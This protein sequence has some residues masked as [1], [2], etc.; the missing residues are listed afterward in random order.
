MPN[1][2]YCRKEAE[3][4]RKLAH[5]AKDSEAAIR[6]LAL[7]RDYE[8]HADE[9][10]ERSRSVLSVSHGPLQQQEIQQ[11]PKKAEDGK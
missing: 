8:A 11:Q 6:W 10:D 3:R 4:C 1:A 2:E 7:A 9:I 5:E